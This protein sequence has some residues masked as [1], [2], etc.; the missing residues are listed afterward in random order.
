MKNFWYHLLFVI[1]STSCN[2]TSGTL[3]HDIN[4]TSSFTHFN[5]HTHGNVSTFNQLK[6]Y[7]IELI[8]GVRKTVTD[9]FD[10]DETKRYVTD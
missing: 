1:I 9:Y 3:I 10:A 5:C 7:R 6:D 8:D 4:L 2:M